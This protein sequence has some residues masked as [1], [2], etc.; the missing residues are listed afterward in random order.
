MI[1]TRTTFQA[2]YG[3]GDALVTI[4][5]E[6]QPILTAAGARG[7]RILTAASGQFFTV[8]QEMEF[9]SLTAYEESIPKAF[10]DPGFGP[11]FAKMTAVVESGARDFLNI[12]D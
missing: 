11:W 12:V 1:L 10:S 8:T 9:D 6:V 5:K 2:K 7:H 4:L 3:Q